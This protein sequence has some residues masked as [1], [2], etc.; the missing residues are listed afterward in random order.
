[1]EVRPLFS[2]PF[3]LDPHTLA[4]DDAV[5]FCVA[6][7]VAVLVNAEGQAFAAALLGDSRPGAKDR[8]HFNA[9]L[10]LDVLGT[11]SFLATG[12]G[13]PKM[14]SV[15]TTKF[16]SPAL[17][18]LFTRAAGPFANFLMANI[19]ASLVWLLK[20][21]SF[22]PR[23]FLMI[24]AVNVT[25]AVYNLLPLAPMAAG[26]LVSVVLTPKNPLLAQMYQRVGPYAL[27]SVLILDRLTQGKVIGTF[28]APIV[29]HLFTMLIK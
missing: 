17:Y 12:M 29:Q 1:M 21:I 16:K 24:L 11:L 25:V 8:L 28:L 2:V 10:H 18:L 19:A 26:T 5:S 14:I 20:T 9:F 22:D 7:L 4:V 3:F 6:V 13:W 27:L 23:V 15:D